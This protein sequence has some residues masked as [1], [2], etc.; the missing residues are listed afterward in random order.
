MAPPVRLRGGGH[1][2][3]ATVGLWRFGEGWGRTCLVL[4]ATS[5]PRGSAIWVSASEG[6]GQGFGLIQI[7]AS[8]S[9]AQLQGSR[10]SSLSRHPPYN[11]HA[12]GVRCSYCTVAGP[13]D[14]CDKAGLR[15][16]TPCEEERVRVTWLS[17]GSLLT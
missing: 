2:R 17:E 3:G 16:L 4:G 10:R 6:V 11:P 1:S 15:L 9:P 8:S 13:T 12:E 7:Q 14:S 5:S